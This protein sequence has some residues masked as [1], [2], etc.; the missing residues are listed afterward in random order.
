MY[1]ITEIVKIKE[2]KEINKLRKYQKK[3][4]LNEYKTCLY[5]IYE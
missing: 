1:H 3:C 4:I 2:K 5:I